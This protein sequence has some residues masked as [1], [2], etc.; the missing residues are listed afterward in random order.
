M[1]SNTNFYGKS[2]PVSGYRGNIL[3]HI[4]IERGEESIFVDVTLL[5]DFKIGHR[6]RQSVFKTQI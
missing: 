4:Q 5:T 3:Q 2:S 1:E 6:T